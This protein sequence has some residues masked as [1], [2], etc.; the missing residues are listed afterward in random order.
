MKEQ[1]LSLYTIILWLVLIYLAITFGVW[2]S[3]IKKVWKK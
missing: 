2:K 1:L 3:E